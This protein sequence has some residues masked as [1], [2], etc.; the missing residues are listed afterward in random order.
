[1]IVLGVFH[2]I[3]SVL[4]L[5]DRTRCYPTVKFQNSCMWQPVIGVTIILES[6][7]IGLVCILYTVQ[8]W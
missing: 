7:L 5:G 8:V 2:Q 1:V 3:E 6:A 4:D